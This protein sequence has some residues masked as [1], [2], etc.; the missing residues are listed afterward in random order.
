[1]RIYLT[2]IVVYYYVTTGLLYWIEFDT[3]MLQFF[4]AIYNF[5]SVDKLNGLFDF[6]YFSIFF[7]NV[8]TLGLKVVS[9]T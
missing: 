9:K 1:M 7:I 5:Y 2:N 3:K 8:E 6:M 4:K